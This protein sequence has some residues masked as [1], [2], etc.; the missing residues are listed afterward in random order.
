MDD[1]KSK[2]VT[3]GIPTCN[4][5]PY[6]EDALNSVLRQELPESVEREVIV[7]ANGCTDGTEGIVESVALSNEGVELISTSEKGRPNAITTIKERAKSDIIVYADDDITFADDK[8]IGRLYEDL[9]ADPAIKVAGGK[10]VYTYKKNWFLI[11]GINRVISR[12]PKR[13]KLQG[14]IFAMRKDIGLDMPKEVISEDSWLSLK[15]EDGQLMIDDDAVVFHAMPTTVR[16]MLR[17]RARIEAGI[18]QL[19]SKY[20]LDTFRIRQVRS[21]LGLLKE[22]PLSELAYWPAVA[23]LYCTAKVA[24]GVGYDLG[25]FNHKYER[26][27]KPV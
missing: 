14:A 9:E 19:K 18:Y 17:Y 10:V 2:R 16:D 11:D 26:C 7:C 25:W 23:A 8:V 13:K 27:V 6:I 20:G 21:R 3:V 22:S 15:L 12:P 5:A 24:G 4:G 1:L